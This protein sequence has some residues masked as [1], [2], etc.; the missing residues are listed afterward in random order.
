MKM[1]VKPKSAGKPD[2]KNHSQ[3]NDLSNLAEAIISN[4]GVGIYIIQHGQFVYVSQLYEKLTGYNCA[5]LIGAYP[6]GNIYPDDRETVRE[7]AIKCLKGKRVEPYE[8]RFFKKNNEVMWVLETITPIVYKG[9]RA[10]LGSFMDI[11]GR[12]QA[13]S[14]RE[15]ALEDLRQSEE[16]YRDILEN[17][18]ESYYEL[19]LDGNLTF[20]NNAV[21][22]NI[23]YSKDELIGMNYRQYTE[24]EELQR[25]FQAY[26]KVYT[27]GEPLDEFG[28]RITR[29][30]GT[31]M[32][33]E[34]SVAL[35]KD[36]EGK[37]IGFKGIHH[38]ITERKQ[39]EEE[40]RQSEEKYRTIIETI[41]D[42]YY[43]I[44][45]AGKYTF[46]NDVICEHLQYSKEELIGK[47]NRQYQ[48]EANA[49][50]AYK[51][52]T[53]V[54]ITGNPV[55]AFEMEVIRKDGTIQISEVSISLIRDTKGNPIAFR[56]TSRDITERKRLEE[57][58]RQSQQELQ[59]LTDVSPIA[60]CWADMQG[61]I[62]YNN[63]KFRELFG[64]TIKDIPNIDAWRSLAYPDPAYREQVPSLIGL[65]TEARKQGKEAGSIEVAITCKD[66]SIRHVLQAGAFTSNRILVTYADITE[67]K[68]MEKQLSHMATHD[69]LTGLPNR[70]MFNQLLAHAIQ[71]A[72]RHKRQFAVLF[73]DL[74][75]FK[76]INDTMGHVAGDQLL[77][78]IA[79]RFKQ[80]MRAADVVGRLEGD[81]DVVGRLGG[82]EF[83]ILIEEV[84]ELSQISTVAQKIL[85]T[86][87]KPIVLLGKECRVTASIGISIY[88]NDGEDEQTL[89]K[90]A[91]MAM[92]HA[93]EEGKNNYQF[94]SKDIQSQSI[95]QFSIETNM[96][97]ALERN[98]FSLLY[99]GKLDFKTG[100]I[101]GVEALLRWQNP[102]L[103]SVT[104][105]QFIPV[106][107]E[108]GL[109]VPIGRWV[110]K[111]VCAQNVVWQ[112][113]G[114]PPVCMSVNL[115]LRQ[116]MDDKLLDDIKAA[117]EDSGM[118]PN[119]LE[120]EITESIIMHNPAHLIAVL[121]KI[122][123][124]G[125]RLAL[126]DF[127]TGYSSLAQ[128]KHFPIDTL[129]VDRSFIRNLPQNSEDRTIIEAIIAMGK[130]LSLTVVAE[131]VETQEQEDFLREHICDEMQ[132]Y[133]F[134]KPI[135]PD[136]FGELLRKHA[137]HLQ[138]LIR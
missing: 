87:I 82:D 136:Q 14:Q 67:R 72:R 18:Q 102:Y 77:Q 106:A 66:G 40:L 125:V 128:I 108:T 11:T 26:S 19:D 101:T 99:Q 6:V 9:E 32:Y 127:G 10:T 131:G 30:D 138:E 135:M 54:L 1:T 43:E 53:E 38:D 94:Y 21:C 35:K 113:Q 52:F 75:R 137:P 110:M 51:I 73:I 117:L 130:T 39:M 69:T 48:T 122:K 31:K 7:E 63:R 118:A 60:I 96:R 22:R 133:Y 2:K 8:Y 16:K 4:S 34:G 111:T 78:E 37:P 91:D 36:S 70:L 129:K 86:T 47:S 57:Q 58:L 15:T 64:Y 112:R 89:M 98:E 97:F 74:D 17:I 105:T 23:G 50:K 61:N 25:V 3:Q 20:V 59:T 83:V 92:Y 120:L 12:K 13:E 85:S 116:L 33:I 95:E 79:A 104:P 65:L 41:Q 107:E 76:I 27:T 126:D 24:K 134:S 109:I 93:K 132:G 103:G 28:W 71:T 124:M 100:M 46:V 44:D 81:D 5:E 56:G 49:K 68:Q 55:K 121:T 115:S 123:E 80:S 114:L 45:L 90:N 119:L 29:K 84:Q 88:P 62:Q 42:G